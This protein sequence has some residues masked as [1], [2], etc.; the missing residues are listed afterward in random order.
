MQITPVMEGVYAPRW[1]SSACFCLSWSFLTTQTSFLIPSAPIFCSRCS[2]FFFR[3]IVPFAML[4]KNGWLGWWRP[5]FTIWWGVLSCQRSLRGFSWRGRTS[6]CCFWND[7][8]NRK[9]D[10]MERSQNKDKNR[11]CFNV[12]VQGSFSVTASQLF[13]IKDGNSFI[14]TSGV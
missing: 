1:H 12:N 7:I 14:E 11:T 4:S 6:P 3:V 13:K 8:N 2:Y 5:S 10:S 9:E